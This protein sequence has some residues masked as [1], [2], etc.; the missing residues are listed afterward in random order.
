MKIVDAAPVT[1]GKAT[2]AQD[3]TR[4]AIASRSIEKDEHDVEKADPAFAGL[5]IE[6]LLD[7]EMADELII[8]AEDDDI[9]LI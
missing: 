6:Y 5:A 1:H 4:R 2:T 7:E 9:T 8:D 3:I